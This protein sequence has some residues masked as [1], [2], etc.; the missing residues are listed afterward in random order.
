MGALSKFKLDGKVALVTG[1]SRGLGKAMAI[2]LAEAGANIVVAALH[3]DR[4]EETAHEIEKLGVKAIAIKVD[5]TDEDDVSKMTDKTINKFG[6]I[7]ILL[8]NAGI[9]IYGHAEEMPKKQ[10]DEVINVNLNGVFLCSKAVGKEMIKNKKGSIINVSSM[11]GYVSNYSLFQIAYNASKAGVIHFTRSLA[12]EWAKYNIRVNGIAPGYMRTEMTEK[13]VTPENMAKYFVG[14]T[15]M[16]RIGEPEE[17]QGAAIYL[18]SEA[19]SYMTGNTLVIDGG[20]I[21][22]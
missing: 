9:C 1:G 21:I 5:V 3:I 12:A 11:S 17:L 10:W 15:P 18:A 16:Q 20:F 13:S 8:N 4:A 22:H 6:K 14:P 19:S 7:D 2:G